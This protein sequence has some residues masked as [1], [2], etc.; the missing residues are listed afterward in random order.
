MLHNIEKLNNEQKELLRYINGGMTDYELSE[1]YDIEVGTLSHKITRLKKILGNSFPQ[2]KH[3]KCKFKNYL[4]KEGIIGEIKWMP[5]GHLS[6]KYYKI[7]VIVRNHFSFLTYKK[8][9]NE[10]DKL[11][12]KKKKV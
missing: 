9:K 3:K 2:R 6:Q 12:R 7:E 5:Q 4:R 1:L 11:F 8:E 10:I